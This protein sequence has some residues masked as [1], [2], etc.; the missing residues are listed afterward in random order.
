MSNM[1]N[2]QNEIENEG[3]YVVS[4]RLSVFNSI[5]SIYGSRELLKRLVSKEIKIKYKN[6]FLGFLWTMLNP[7]LYLV[8]YWIVFTKFLPNGIPSF[9]V[10]FLSG[11]L[12][13]NVFSA[14][15]SIA[16]GSIT[17][18]ASIVKKVSF[19]REV[20]PL[21]S[22]GTSIFHYLLQSCVLAIALVAFRHNIDWKF[23]WLLPVAFLC[24]VVFASAL[25]IIVASVN[26][27]IRDVQHFLELILL[28]WF[29]MT[30]VIYS[31]AR[32]SDKNLVGLIVRLNPMTYI[33][34]T[35]QRVIYRIISDNG[36][37]IL[38]DVGATWY[39]YHLLVV[40][41]FSVV[42]FCFAIWLFGRL[43][44]NF[45]EEI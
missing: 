29:W 1:Q 43:E 35:F 27:Y 17:G 8:V 10:Y 2:I 19:V 32:V 21:S 44:V 4:E 14:S 36:I 41:A 42:L 5:K 30:P 34:L 9:A 20:L 28:V 16:A 11:M 39:L 18:N 31:F 6:S 7:A 33:V 26:V 37:N 15:L 3:F 25:G 38:P 22:V 45:A 13:W 24:L 23:I 40:L 12:L